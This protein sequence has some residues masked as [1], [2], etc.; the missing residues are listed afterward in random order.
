MLSFMSKIRKNNASRKPASKAGLFAPQKTKIAPQIHKNSPEMRQ[1]TQKWYNKLADKGFKDIEGYTAI[2]L[3][4]GPINGASLRN[5]ADNFSPETRH[6]YA[7][8]R[9]YLTFKEVI[10][11]VYGAPI[12]PTKRLAIELYSEGVPYR[13][14]LKQLKGRQGPALNLFSL[15]KLINYFVGI[16][17]HWNKVNH[18]GLDY[19][20]DIGP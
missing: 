4:E 10:L 16:A 8:L 13:A 1:L 17:R 19:I 3:R 9:C 11:D 20:S 18:N 6:Y 14:I 15:S 5:F 2:G 7:Q 12:G